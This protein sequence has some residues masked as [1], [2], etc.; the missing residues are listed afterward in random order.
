MGADEGNINSIHATDW[1]PSVR[2][3]PSG[4]HTHAI[5]KEKLC[6]RS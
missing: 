6:D 1:N 2:V 4:A 3:V 5:G